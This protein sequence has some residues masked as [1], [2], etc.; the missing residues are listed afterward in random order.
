MV[1]RILPTE[2]RLDDPQPPATAEKKG[3]EIHSKM[4]FDPILSDA[5]STGCGSS[6]DDGSVFSRERLFQE[7][8]VG[9][10]GGAEFALLEEFGG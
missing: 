9:Y 5:V 7:A 1:L 8:G 10:D 4:D 3:T 6:V 2:A